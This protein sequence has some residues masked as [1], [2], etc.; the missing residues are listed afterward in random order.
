MSDAAQ[1]ASAYFAAVAARD[2]AR[3]AEL[4][5]PDAELV[6]AAAVFRGRDE[7]T[8]F[9]VGSSFVFD[10]LEPRPG[11]LLVDGDHVAVEIELRLG[12]KISQ[13]AD[14]FTITDGRIRRLAIYSGASSDD[15]TSILTGEG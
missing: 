4:F 14:F 3:I 7:I 5:A 1:V 2:G 9:F 10:D 6:T 15:V 13:L 11:P 12:G 8:R